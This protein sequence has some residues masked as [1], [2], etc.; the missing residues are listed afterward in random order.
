MWQEV[1]KFLGEDLKSMKMG[2]PEKFTNFINAVIDEK[3]FDKIAK[4]IDQAKKSND[5]SILFGGRYDKTE[6]YFI[7]PTVILAKTPNYVS[8]CE[9][10]FGPVLTIYVYADNK[11]DETLALVDSNSYAL[12]GAL[13]AKDREVIQQASYTL[14]NAAGNYYIND[15]PTGAVVGQ[16]P[17][18]GARASGTNDKAG[19]VLNLYRWVS[20]RTIKENF[21]P[22]SDYR[23]PFM[24]EE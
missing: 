21:A 11:W 15:K 23:Y 18:G 14:R 24:L 3:S 1:K 2:S 4:S 19:S 7:E 20:P 6:G 9:E 12:T 8:M 17:F 16:Q 22:P 10:I 13:F 5:A